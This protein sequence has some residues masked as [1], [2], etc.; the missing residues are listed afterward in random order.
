M[1]SVLLRNT[2]EVHNVE[3]LCS[4]LLPAFHSCSYPLFG[5]DLSSQITTS[6]SSS[7]ASASFLAGQKR[8]G[9]LAALKLLLGLSHDVAASRLSELLKQSS[10]LGCHWEKVKLSSVC[11]RGCTNLLS[12]RF[13]MK[14]KWGIPAA[15][16]SLKCPANSQPDLQFCNEMHSWTRE[17]GLLHCLS[18]TPV[19]WFLCCCFFSI[20]AP[21]P[22]L[23]EGGCELM[24]PCWAAFTDEP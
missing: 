23:L 11:E 12:R 3:N 16:M 24:F 17:K 4:P 18:R 21:P 22:S 20:L 5:C 2:E 6:T 10:W 8:G 19:A 14:I 13:Y 9:W 7:K 1:H 15:F